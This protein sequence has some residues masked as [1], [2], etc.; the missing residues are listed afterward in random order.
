[1]TFCTFRRI[2]WSCSR[3]GAALSVIRENHETGERKL[4]LLQWGL[5]PHGCEDPDGSLN[6]RA[7]TMARLRTFRDAYARRRCLV[8]VDCF[9]EWGVIR[10]ARAKQPFA[11]ARKDRAPFA[12]A[13]LRENWRHPH[14]GEWVRTF[15]ILTVSANDLVAKINGRMPLIL[16]KIACERCQ[17]LP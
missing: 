3:P 5:I 12:L 10:G 8:P 11:V 14:M 1:V 17:S 9:Y 15:V 4:D 7:E 2:L 16:A 13:G 6:A